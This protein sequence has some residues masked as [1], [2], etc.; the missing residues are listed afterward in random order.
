[1]IYYGKSNLRFGLIVLRRES[2]VV[3]FDL[4]VIPALLNCQS[5]GLIISC[6]NMDCAPVNLPRKKTVKLYLAGMQIFDRD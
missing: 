6:F 2:T 1:L 3:N 4:D 5:I